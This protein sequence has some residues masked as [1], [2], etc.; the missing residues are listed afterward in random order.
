MKY[1]TI[2]L[3]F[4]I[5]CQ[6]PAEYKTE[7]KT[8]SYPNS[9]DTNSREISYQ[10]DTTFVIGNVS[11][12]NEFP[13]GRLN[14]FIKKN[15]TTYLATIS[16]ENAPINSS[17]WYA[18]QIWTSVPK[19]VYVELNYTIHRHRYAPKI[20]SDGENWTLLDS[21]NVVMSKDTVNATLKLEIGKKKLWVAA[22]EINDHKRVG[23]WVS[24]LSGSEAVKQS[25]AGTSPLGR[26]L[27]HM[28]ITNGDPTNKPTVLIISRQHPPEVTGYFAMQAFV[29]TIIQNGSKNGFLDRFR[30]MVYPL[31]NPDGVDLGHFRHNTGGVDLNRDWANYNQSEIRQVTTHMVETTNKSNNPV[32]LGLDFHSTYRDVYYTFDDSIDP[33]YPGFTEAWLNQ[34]KEGLGVEKLNVAPSGLGAPVS[35][36]WF[37][38]QFGVESITYEIGDGTPRDFI[39]KKGEVSADAMMSVL[40]EM[41]S[42]PN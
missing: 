23:D 25:E 3:F 26:S 13:S 40:M 36:G 30:V 29:E 39:R 17:P 14:D 7:W 15:D 5:S 2:V 32:V 21:G 37:Y 8:H 10:V 41:E 27:Y 20:S 33:I 35:K 12:T 38:Q 9:V 1:L 31:M 42:I 24:K 16:A 19:T 4:A 6:Q 22:Q 18:F 34:I 11:A 28:D